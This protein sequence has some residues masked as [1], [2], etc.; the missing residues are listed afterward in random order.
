MSGCVGEGMGVDV[1][2][3]GAVSVGMGGIGEGAV[4]AVGLESAGVQALIWTRK[5]NVIARSFIRGAKGATFMSSPDN[6]KEKCWH[7]NFITRYMD[8]VGKRKGHRV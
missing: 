2:A 4:V 7:T 8:R 6:S 1:G 5:I 3:G